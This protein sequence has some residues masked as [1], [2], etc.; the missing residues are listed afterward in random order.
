MA[1]GFLVAVPIRNA[2]RKHSAY[3][4][5]EDDLIVKDEDGTYSKLCPGLAV[6]GFELTEAQELELTPVDFKQHGLDFKI[7]PAS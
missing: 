7:T 2:H 4:L 5:L 3:P 6:G 1:T